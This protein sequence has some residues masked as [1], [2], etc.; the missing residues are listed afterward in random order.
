M[1]LKLGLRI[2]THNPKARITYPKKEGTRYQV[3]DEGHGGEKLNTNLP[4]IPL[5]L[6][7]GVSTT[8]YS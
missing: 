8:A 5:P 4:S 6:T 1:D 3:L 7:P 2:R